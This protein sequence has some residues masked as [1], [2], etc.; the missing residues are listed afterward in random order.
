MLKK[1]KNNKKGFTLVELIVVL[2]ILVILAALLV[3][4]LTGYINRAKEKSA[5]AEARQVVMAAQTIANEKT[6]AL[7]INKYTNA[8]TDEEVTKIIDLAEVKGTL[9]AT[10]VQF[11]ETGAVTALTYTTENGIVVNYS[12]SASEPYTIGTSTSTTTT[13][14]GE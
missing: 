1:M 9:E 3:P 2:V 13:T 4:A 14:A 12:K 5:I 8:V 10:S 11:D 6:G 7:D